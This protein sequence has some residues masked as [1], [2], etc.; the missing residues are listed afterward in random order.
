MRNK[1]AKQLRKLAANVVEANGGHLMEG[2]NRYNQETN[3]H[4]FEVATDAKGLPM[5]DTHGKPLL[6]H[7]LVPGTIHLTWK[8]RLIY[9]HIKK[10]WKVNP[11]H[12]AFNL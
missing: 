12:P 7:T 8:R 5:G 4:A 10:L 11:G 1:R 2:Y 9:Q 3:C 6:K